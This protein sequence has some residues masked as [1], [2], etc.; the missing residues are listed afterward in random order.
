MYWGKLSRFGELVRHN[1]PELR[2]LEGDYICESWKV[3]QQEK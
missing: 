2:D 3:G 1:A